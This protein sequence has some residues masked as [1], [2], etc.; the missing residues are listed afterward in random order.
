[1]KYEKPQVVLLESAIKAIQSG[2]ITKAQNPADLNN[3]PSV[4]AYEAD[5]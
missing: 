3:K 1:M 4:P 2:N 5:E